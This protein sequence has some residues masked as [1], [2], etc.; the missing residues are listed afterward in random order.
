V[1]ARRT[2]SRRAAA[3]APAALTCAPRNR[4]RR[5]RS[6]RAGVTT[7]AAKELYF[8]NQDGLCAPRAA[9]APRH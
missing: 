9:A 3:R 4:L 8:N 2:L 1:R 5:H 7:R 6:G